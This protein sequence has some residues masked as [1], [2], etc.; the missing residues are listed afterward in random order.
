[1]ASIKISKRT[2]DAAAK[3]SGNDA[4]YWDSELKGFGLRVTPKGVRS[5]VVQY[6]MRGMPAKR[7]TL[8]VHGAPWTAEKARDTAQAILIDVK[9]GIDPVAEAKRRDREA[10]TLEFESYVIDRFVAGCLKEE[11]KDSWADVEKLLRTHVVP[12]LKGKALPHITPEDIKEVIDKVRPQKALARKVWAVLSR[13][14]TWAID[15]RDLTKFQNPMDELKAPP[16]P[17]ARKRVLFPGELVALWRASYKLNDPWGPFVRM[18][19]TT[20]QRRN[21][22]SGL[23]WKELNRTAAVWII[24]G[25]RA[26]NEEDHL[27]PLNVLAQRELKALGWKQRSFVFTTTG[28]TPVSGFSKMKKQL[29]RHMLAALQEL[30]NERAEAAGEDPEPV[31]MGRWTLHDLRR[32][33]ATGLQ[34]LGTPIEVVETLLNHKEGET[35]KGIRKIYNLHKYENEKAVALNKWAIHLESLIAGASA[36]NVVALAERRA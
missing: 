34:A 28:K 23:P 11:W 5:Y 17:P 36:P 22:V 8:G 14:F 15:E 10:R 18:L 35:Q 31:V 30:E 3:P 7:M 25:E 1:M 33:G 20:L 9:R 32:T 27:V 13:L 29:D 2:V 4:Y 12:H 19:V 26:K 6:R 21:E 24:D 16:V